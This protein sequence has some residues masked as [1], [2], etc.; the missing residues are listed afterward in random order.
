[1]SRLKIAQEFVRDIA[2]HAGDAAI[3]RATI[4]LARELGIDVVAEGVETAAALRLIEAAGCRCV[5]GYY[6]SRPV[7]ADVAGD[8]LR[9][10]I[11]GP[12]ADVVAAPPLV[13]ADVRV[14]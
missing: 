8:L 5:Q 13:P 10:V 11:L 6:F 1:V 12:Q 3:V 4:G 9:R 7:P 14:A 2:T